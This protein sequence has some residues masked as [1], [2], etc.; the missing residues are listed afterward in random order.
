VTAVS[1]LVALVL[2]ADIVLVLAG[3]DADHVVVRAVAGTA[4]TL[5]WGFNNV[6]TNGDDKARTFLNYGLAAVVYLS[7]G[8]I[9]RR[10]VSTGGGAAN[11][12]GR[13]GSL[14]ARAIYAVFGLVTLVLV[15]DIIFVLADANAD[16]SL[17][18]AVGDIAGTLAWAF[19]NVFTNVGAK[20]HTAL[21]QGLAAA[22]YLLIGAILH[23]LFGR[24][25]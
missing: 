9:L 1:G 25:G 3:A 22:V 7:I 12:A 6:F 4:G 17:V 20:V 19:N 8:G 15:V 23:R 14:P 18:S 2:V 13:R 11:G 5:A 16:N 24:L 10:M 21:S